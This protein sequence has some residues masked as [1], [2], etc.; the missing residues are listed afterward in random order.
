[1]PGWPHD[2]RVVKVARATGYRIVATSRIHANT[3][4]T[5]AFAL[6]RVAILRGMAS[7]DFAAICS[8]Q[9]LPRLRARGAL[10][11]AAKRWWGNSLYDRVREVCWEGNAR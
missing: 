8:G 2:D 10:R 9:V 7:E 5:N 4:G 1:M 11:D 6:G 3:A